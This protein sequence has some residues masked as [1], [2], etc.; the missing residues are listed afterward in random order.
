MAVTLGV[1]VVLL[2]LAFKLPTSPAAPFVAV[3]LTAAGALGNLHD[4]LFRELLIVGE[5][6]RPG[7]VDFIVVFVG[8]GRRWPAFN[9]ADVALLIGG[10]VLFWFLAR[11][12]GHRSQ[13]DPQD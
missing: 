3:G 7:V 1:S 2:R 5:G 11:R 12:E 9:V 4:R 8:K 10:S 6:I 13:G